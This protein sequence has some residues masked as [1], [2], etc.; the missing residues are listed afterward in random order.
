MVREE[1]H[2]ENKHLKVGGRERNFKES[3][4]VRRVFMSLQNTSTGK[5]LKPCETKVIPNFQTR[6]LRLREMRVTHLARATPFL[7]CSEPGTQRSDSTA[8]TCHRSPVQTY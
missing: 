7:S 4:Y 5:V 1:R 6:T 2:K 8:P 3:I